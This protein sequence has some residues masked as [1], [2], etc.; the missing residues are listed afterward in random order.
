MGLLTI[1][2]DDQINDLTVIEKIL[3]DNNVY[4]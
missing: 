2:H 3:I 1:Y 4:F